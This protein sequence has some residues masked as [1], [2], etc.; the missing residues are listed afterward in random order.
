MKGIFLAAMG[1]PGSGKSSVCGSLSRGYNFD[2][3]HEPEEES[4]PPAVLDRDVSGCFSALMWFRSIRVPLYYKALEHKRRGRVAIVDSYYDKLLNHYIQKEGMEWLIDPKDPYY[5]LALEV[6][7][8]DAS[9]LPDADAVIFFEVKYSDW[10]KQLA[11]RDRAL[12]RNPKFRESFATQDYFLAAAEAY[13]ART[14]AHLLRFKQEF[15]SPAQAADRLR[16]QLKHEG[17]VP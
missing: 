11:W 8:L 7:R 17:I 16:E 10:I 14:G 5:D 13:S 4:W 3:F 15:S 6:A 1:L 12:D 9:H 2:V